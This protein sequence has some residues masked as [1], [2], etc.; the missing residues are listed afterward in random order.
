MINLRQILCNKKLVFF[1]LVNYPKCRYLEYNGPETDT[2]KTITNW[3]TV[4]HD[5]ANK[6]EGLVKNVLGTYQG[7]CTPNGIVYDRKTDSFIYLS[8]LVPFYNITFSTI[9]PK[10][11]AY[12]CEYNGPDLISEDDLCFCTLDQTINGTSDIETL[13]KLGIIGPRLALLKQMVSRE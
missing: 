7:E 5:P 9:F 10:E 11:I 6:K 4:N 12:R 2:Y 1:L 8:L 13:E 3:C